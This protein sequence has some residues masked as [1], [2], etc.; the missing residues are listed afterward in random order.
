MISACNKNRT[1]NHLVRKRT[2]KCLAKL[3]SSAKSLSVHLQTKWLWVRV[4]LQSIKLQISRQFRAMTS[5][6][7][8][9]I[10]Y[11]FTLK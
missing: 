6:T 11:G 7:F 2:I 10:E 5:L 1:H 4:P 3:V 9:Q 8:R